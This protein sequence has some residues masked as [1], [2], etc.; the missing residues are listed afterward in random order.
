LCDVATPGDVSPEVARERPNAML[1][2]G[3]IVRLPLGQHLAIDGM[4]LPTG[5]VYGCL[6]ETV[7]LGLTGAEESLSFGALSADKVRRA[8][9]LARAHG[10]E[11]TKRAFDG[12]PPSSSSLKEASAWSSR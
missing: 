4:Q 12:A 7:L 2:K 9:A 10:F 8:R 3:G 6:A 5:Q 11:F 1:L